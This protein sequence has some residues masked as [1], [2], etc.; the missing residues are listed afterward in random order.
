MTNSLHAIYAKYAINISIVHV[1]SPLY[2]ISNGPKRATAEQIILRPS[3]SL[4][5]QKAIAEAVMGRRVSRPSCHSRSCARAR[6]CQPDLVL[7]IL[8]RFRPSD[9]F[10]FHSR[11]PLLRSSHSYASDQHRYFVSFVLSAIVNYTGVS[12]RDKTTVCS[13]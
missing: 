8:I 2:L 3:G 4:D 10:L 11:C 5:K 9:L 13:I 12:C 1:R 7:I 6:A